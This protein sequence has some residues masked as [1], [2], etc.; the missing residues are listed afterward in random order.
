MEIDGSRVMQSAW[1]FVSVPV[2]VALFT[3]MLAIRLLPLDD[4]ITDQGVLYSGNDPWYHMRIV[5]LIVAHFPSSPQFDAWSHFPYGT[6]RHSGFGGLFDQ[7]IAFG[8]LILGG[9]SPSP[10]LV[11]IVG[12]VAPAIFGAATIIPAYFI[13]KMIADRWT[14]LLASGILALTSGQ[15][16]NRTVVGSPDHQSAEALF[17]TIAVLGFMVALKAA[18]EHKP[19]TAHLKD[20]DLEGLGPF[21]KPAVL[22]GVGIASY[23]MLWPPG[24]MLVFT[25]GVFGVLQVVRDHMTGKPTEYTV[26]GVATPMLVTAVFT[27]LYA[28][29]YGLSST[30]FSLLQPLLAVGIAAGMVYLY[31]LASSLDRRDHE[32]WHFPVAVVGSIAAFFAILAVVYPRG[33]EMFLK[34]I[35]R[36]YS[37]GLLSTETALT[38]A[39]IAP[40][41]LPQAWSAF[42]FTFLLA[43]GAHALLI[44]R[45]VMEDRPLELVVLLWSLTMISA[46]FTMVRFGYYVAV[47]VAV[48]SAFLLIWFARDVMAFDFDVDDITDV[49]GYEVITIL[50]IAILLIP[51]NLVAVAGT[52]PPVWETAP[53]LGGT[54]S[55]WVESLDWLQQNTPEEPLS[56]TEYQDEPSDGDYDY[57]VDPSPL[58]GAY[59]VM[60][61]WDYGHWITVQGRRIPFANP[62]QEGPRPASEFL[63]SQTETRSELVLEALPSIKD[64]QEDIT[65][66][67]NGDLREVVDGQDAQ[68]RNE[69]VRYVIIDD[70]S[71]ANKFGAIA[72]WTGFSQFVSRQNFQ[73]RNETQAFPGLNERYENTTLS[74]LYFDDADGMAHY[75]LVHETERFAVTGSV[76]DGQRGR[77]QRLNRILFRSNHDEKFPNTN[78]SMKRIGSLLSDTQT[79]PAGGGQ[80]LYDIRTAAA[81]KTFER[82]PGARLTGTANVSEPT[83]VTAVLSLQTVNTRRNFTYSRTTTTSADGSF[84]LTV[85]YATD[86]SVTVEDGG[87]DAAVEATSSYDIYVGDVD[88]RRLLGQTVVLGNQSEG[89]TVDVPERAVYEGRDV[90]VSLGPVEQRSFR[91]E[92]GSVVRSGPGS[93]G[94]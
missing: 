31:G 46:Y 10:Q 53:R 15:F 56:F 34:L 21:I 76:I 6:G 41:S 44:Y 48:L 59:G 58:K 19:T 4:V 82:V 42:G 75:R 80:L 14:A 63:T 92:N 55:D 73:I 16:L 40:A 77:V 3:F 45:V 20:S 39:E 30:A 69:D 29:S 84:S 28:K 66:L 70:Q 89:G 27:G 81:V 2:L 37:F 5:R 43:V 65:N 86:D 23:L 94:G 13:V 52:Q 26:F 87:T 78:V 11:D 35:Q 32:P 85:P 17:G 25:F 47:N 18:Y 33:I 24:V 9:G 22:G 1:K 67:S 38:V 93:V 71:A 57:P 61:W 83:D 36:I 88:V 91:P 64:R 60:S 8:A 90:S 79:I 74:R 62:F 51:G 54:N 50:I 49:K 68:E 7:I 12:A 72:T